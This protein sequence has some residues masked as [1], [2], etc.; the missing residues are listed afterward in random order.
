MAWNKVNA[1]LTIAERRAMATKH[2]MKYHRLYSVYQNMMSRC[3]VEGAH[4][5]KNYGARGISVCLGWYGNP[6]AFFKWAFSSG[7]RRGLYLDRIDNGRDYAPQN[8]RWVTPKVSARNRRSTRLTLA[9]AAVVY[10]LSHRGV[11]QKV[12]GALYGLCFQ[13][14]SDIKRGLNWKDAKAYLHGDVQ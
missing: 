7:Y 13:A 11:S 12:V 5:Y 10:D 6:E 4:N 1:N 3:H 9:D 8:C 14:I 2:G